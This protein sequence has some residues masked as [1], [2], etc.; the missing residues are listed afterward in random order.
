MAF[1]L[2]ERS[3]IIK[4]VWNVGISATHLRRFYK[5]NRVGYRQAKQ[6]FRFCNLNNDAL[7][8]ERKA[9]AV[10]LGNLVVKKQA[11]I[12]S[13]ESTF[14]NQTCQSKSWGFRD[15]PN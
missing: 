15:V 13:D 6:V 8:K 5:Q 3:K 7:T 14:N 10:T 4:R 11:I 12:Y 1:T 2:T 9:F